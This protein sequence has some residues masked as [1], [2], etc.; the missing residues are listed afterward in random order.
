MDWSNERYVRFYVRE[1][2]D[3]TLW[4][5]QAHAIWPQILRRADRSG[6]IDIG[7]HSPVK[8]IAAI[9]RFPVEV[10]EVGLDAL[11]VDECLMISGTQ[12][13]LRNYIPAQESVMSDAQRQRESRAHKAIEKA[14]R[15]VTPS[16]TFEQTVTNSDNAS[17]DMTLGHA[18]SRG[19]TDGHV[20][21]LCA[22]PS[23]PSVPSEERESARANDVV[24]LPERWPLPEPLPDQVERP[25]ASRVR[26]GYERRY[27]ARYAVAP[28]QEK[29]PPMVPK[30]CAWLVAVADARGL[31]EYE[32]CDQL[33][34]AFFAHP[35]AIENRHR[36]GFLSTDPGEWLDAPKP[37]AKPLTQEDID[38]ARSPI[39][40]LL[41]RRPV[42]R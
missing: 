25:L 36:P 15:G 26:Q 1:T 40:K 7:K 41:P 10:C 2:V 8:A 14:R 30:V 39:R 11:F 24:P 35:K 13:V 34:D 42:A 32:L 29:T 20:R 6:V 31:D 38:S 3:E 27:F 4:P 23:V 28:N 22:V 16:D 9:I 5:W 17:Q 21:S 37:R 18:E 33:L 12:L 19:V